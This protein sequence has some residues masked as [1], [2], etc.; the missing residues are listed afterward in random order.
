MIKHHFYDDY[1]EYPYISES[2]DVLEWERYPERFPYG[3][4]EKRQMIRLEEGILPGH[5]ILLWRIGFDNF[6]TE[7]TIPAYFEYRYGIHT[8]EAFK[9]LMQK[10]YVEMCSAKESISVI[11]MTQIKRILGNYQLPKTG[12]RSDLVERVLDNLTE[13]E[14]SQE[15]EVRRYT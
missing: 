13:E 11:N 15:F 14:L 2:R 12:K 10:G 9:T 5:V 8:D 7:S 1:A 4:V 3:I 6:T